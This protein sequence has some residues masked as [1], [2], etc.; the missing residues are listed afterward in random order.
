MQYVIS[1]SN[2]NYVYVC[3]KSI[4]NMFLNFVYVYGYARNSVIESCTFISFEAEKRWWY[5]TFR[6]YIDGILCISL[7]NMLDMLAFH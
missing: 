2:S 1:K 4:F 7:Q 5:D 6:M 3:F